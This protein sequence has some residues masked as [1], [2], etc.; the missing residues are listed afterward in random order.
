MYWFEMRREEFDFGTVGNN[1][2]ISINLTYMICV[3]FV[4]QQRKHIQRHKI[5][6]RGG[7]ILSKT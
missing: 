4:M 7:T 2:V 1:D 3:A 5:R 6:T